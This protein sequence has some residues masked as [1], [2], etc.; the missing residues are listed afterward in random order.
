MDQNVTLLREQF[1]REIMEAANRVDGEPM[2]TCAQGCA[3]WVS[4][5]YAKVM[6]S[7]PAGNW[8]WIEGRDNLLTESVLGRRGFVRAIMRAANKM[9]WPSVDPKLALPGDIALIK[10][11]SKYGL[12]IFD[13]LLWNSRID[14]GVGGYPHPS[15]VRAWSVVNPDGH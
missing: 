3:L 6:G 1:A 11:M 5:I 8:R 13:G 2:D 9:G 12:A 7:D 10:P 14:F 15:V 4:D